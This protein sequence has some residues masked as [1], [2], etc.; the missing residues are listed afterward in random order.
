MALVVEDL[1]TYYFQTGKVTPA[2][3]GVSFAVSPEKTVCLVG[4]SGCGKSAV[5]L[6]LLGLI[7]PPGKIVTGRISLDGRNLL[8]LPPEE[9]R[10][11]RGQDISIIFQN[12][13]YSL[14]PSLTIGIQLAETVL[15]H[16]E[17]SQSA[18]KEMA[19]DV[20]RRVRLPEPV[21]LCNRYPFEL[22]GGMQQRVMIAMALLLKPRYLIADEP[23]SALDITTQ[24]HILD[25]LME[26]KEQYGAGMLFITHDL[27]VVAEIADEVAVMRQGKIVEYGSVF[28]VFQN[29][30]HPY[31]RQLLQAV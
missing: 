9:L 7:E 14:N 19:V 8:T 23:T 28:E 15:S 29:P 11:L 24:T 25:E 22:S 26:L 16:R 12:S 10:L 21:K 30:A 4:E 31:T 3:D 5:A 1:R 20:L 27:A 17:V 18:A 2:V 6:S 13:C